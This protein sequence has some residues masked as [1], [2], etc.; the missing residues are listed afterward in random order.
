MIRQI[1]RNGRETEAG[2]GWLTRLGSRYETQ[3][4]RAFQWGP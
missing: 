3:Q 4:L 2:G 1:L